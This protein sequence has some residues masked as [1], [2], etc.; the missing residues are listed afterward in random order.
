MISLLE[1]EDVYGSQLGSWTIKAAH[2]SF[3]ESK[4]PFMLFFSSKPILQMRVT[5]EE[6][7]AFIQMIIAVKQPSRKSVP[8]CTESSDS[9][10]FLI[11]LD[12]LSVLFF[13]QEKDSNAFILSFTL[14]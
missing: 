13:F 8:L 2:C 14:T 9:V 6:M 10:T 11:S 4:S 7:H 3:K 5:E 12:S 1:E